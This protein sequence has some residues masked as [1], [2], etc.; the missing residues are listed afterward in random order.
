MSIGTVIFLIF[1]ITIA[2]IL[3]GEA[4]LTWILRHVV[5]RGIQSTY[6][7]RPDAESLLGRWH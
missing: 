5:W 6:I 7:D 2:V 3:L 4:A 1:M